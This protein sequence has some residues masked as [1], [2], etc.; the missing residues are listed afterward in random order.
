MLVGPFPYNPCKQVTYLLSAVTSSPKA[1]HRF[2]PVSFQYYITK[3]YC[4]ISALL[5]SVMDS[6]HENSWESCG[7]QFS[8]ARTHLHWE[9]MARGLLQICR[10]P[11]TWVLRDAVDSDSH[12]CRKPC[13]TT[14]NVLPAWP[15][16]V[17]QCFGLHKPTFFLR[18]S[19]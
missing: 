4:R 5:L 2:G 14:A 12:I 8:L 19:T 3:K 18:Q 13:E 6:S 7:Q 11:Q 16:A 1:A 10:K 15:L 17:F 9:T